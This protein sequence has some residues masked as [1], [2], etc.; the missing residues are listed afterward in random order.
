MQ[1]DQMAP[2]RAIAR[3]RQLANEERTA[4]ASR[5]IEALCQIAELLPAAVEAVRAFDPADLPHLQE[6]MKEVQSAQALAEH[7][8]IAE[9]RGASRRLKRCSAGLK[10]MQAYGRQA[11]QAAL[12][13]NERR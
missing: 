9:L 6:T 3:L 13:V 11:P 2:E 5:D 1:R 10:A 12:Q 4:V 8:L 7:L